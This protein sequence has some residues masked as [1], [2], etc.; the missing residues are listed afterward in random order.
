MACGVCYGEDNQAGSSNTYSTG[1]APSET[2]IDPKITGAAR[3]IEPL[4]SKVSVTEGG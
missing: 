2:S 3:L 4:G 1:A